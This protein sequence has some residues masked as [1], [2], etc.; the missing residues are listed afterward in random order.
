MEIQLM[1]AFRNDEGTVIKAS[2]RNAYSEFEISK[3]LDHN[4]EVGDRIVTSK[5]TLSARSVIPWVDW[6]NRKNVSSMGVEQH[7]LNKR[8]IVND[9]YGDVKNRLR[10]YVDKNYQHLSDNQIN[11]ILDIVNM[12]EL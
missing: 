2:H 12:M 11:E 5:V 8:M 4:V 10:E 1:E 7:F 6:V 3:F 9:I